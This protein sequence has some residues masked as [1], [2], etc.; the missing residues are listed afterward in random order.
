MN[1]T[2][3]PEFDGHESVTFLHDRAAGLRSFIA[4]HNTNLGPATGGT[5]YA[6][7]ASEEEALKD[8][9]NLSRA[10]TY[11]CA[12][13]DVPYGGGKGVIMANRKPKTKVLVA[14]YARGV[15]ILGG[16]FTTG[17]DVGITEHD[18]RVMQKE[19]KY[20]NGRP[21]LAGELG[22]WAALG[23]FSAMRAALKAIFGDSRIEG[24][25]FAVKG[26]GKVGS[27]LCAHIGKEGGTIMAAD[28]DPLAIRRAKARFPK[29]K[30]VSPKEIPF[31][32][33]DVFAPC[34][35][36]G[37]FTAETIKKLKCAIVCGGANN[38][39]TSRED[40]TRLHK[41]G[42]LYVPDYVANAGGLINVA[43]EMRKNGYHRA[44]V[45]RKV[46]G[47][48]NTVSEIIELSH[49]TKK[50]MHEV[51]DRLAEARFLGG[52]KRKK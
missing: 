48:R 35:M 50:P 31:V 49:A 30:I 5:R 26:L 7:Y 4:I 19:S 17:E 32:K 44:W 42:I 18:L 8:A 46:L 28:I 21:G 43:G 13:A 45:E 52:R 6:H 23:V 10:M 2:S 47:I 22:P 36:G 11:K 3:L 25:T 12:L 37:D 14:A 27:E 38:Q 16:R 34:A 15:N 1:I 24:K 40:G 29:I 39:L 20:V 33:A 41:R 51:A 9:L